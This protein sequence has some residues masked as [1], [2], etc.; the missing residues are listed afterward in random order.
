MLG[1][2]YISTLESLI[3]SLLVTNQI[4]KDHIQDEHQQQT[5]ILVSKKFATF[6]EKLQA[7]KEVET[8]ISKTY[9]VLLN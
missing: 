6:Q 9:P 1:H 4:L 8:Y 2:T 7:I 3:V 5:T